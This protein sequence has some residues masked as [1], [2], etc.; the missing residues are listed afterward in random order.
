[1][2]SEDTT[3]FQF[4]CRFPIKAMGLAD[5]DFDGLVISIVR[6]HVPRLPEDAVSYRSS[7]GGKYLAVT[8]VIEATSREQL[9]AIYQDLSANERILM[10]L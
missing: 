8:V 2:K 1:M 3:P 10:A 7:R 4:P 5:T 9:D 6:R